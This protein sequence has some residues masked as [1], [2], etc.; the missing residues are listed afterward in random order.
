M[1]IAI[2]KLAERYNFDAKEAM[3]YLQSGSR[4]PRIPLPFCGEIMANML[5]SAAELDS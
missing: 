1:E 3:H 5:W 2:Q 4:R